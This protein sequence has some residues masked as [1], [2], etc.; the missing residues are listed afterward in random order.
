MHH[1]CSLTFQKS[2]TVVDLL[3]LDVFPTDLQYEPYKSA[4][5]IEDKVELT[6]FEKTVLSHKYTQ[7]ENT[8][9]RNWFPKEEELTIQDILN[10]F[11][12]YQF[13]ERLRQFKDAVGIF[14]PLLTI[15]MVSYS[16]IATRCKSIRI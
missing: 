1:T 13:R 15:T 14:S 11:G 4:L 9:L 2:S 8:I 7:T 10:R 6:D 3:E 5:W 16:Q 12:Y